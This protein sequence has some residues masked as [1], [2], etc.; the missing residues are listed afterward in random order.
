[1]DLNLDG[2]VAVVTGSSAGIGRMTAKMLA[3]EG[4]QVV[5]VA[6]RGAELDSL[7]EEIE[8]DG[9]L[10]PLTVS[11]DLVEV[12]AGAQ[13]ADV[14]SERFG[15]VDVLANVHGGSELVSV[16]DNDYWLSQFELNFHSKRRLTE[17]LVPMLRSSDQGRVINF[18]GILEPLRISPAQAAV[19]G[20]IVW[21][22]ALSREVAADGVTVNCLAPGRIESEQLAKLYSDP[23]VRADFIGAR[24]PAG[25]FGRPEEAAGL[26]VFLASGPASYITGEMF[27]VDGGMHWAI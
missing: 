8:A 26:V 1:V 20:C 10:R 17:A 9:G 14:V 7:A 2:R 15:R 27:T 11:A 3:R 18:V 24:I 13:V 12:D 25:R 16:L 21:S 22:K 4:A 5:A 6:R 23:K 19:A